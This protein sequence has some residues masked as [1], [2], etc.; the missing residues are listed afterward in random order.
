MVTW[1]YGSMALWLDG[2]MALWLYGTKAD[3][4]SSKGTVECSGSIGAP[5]GELHTT[6]LP[7]G[8]LRF[9]CS[10]GWG[11]KRPMARSGPRAFGR[12]WAQ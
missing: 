11:P 9:P 12:L 3:K 1:W 10:R 7:R 5:P 6:R 8:Q 4:K 2:S